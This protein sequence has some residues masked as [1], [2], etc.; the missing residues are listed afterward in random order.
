MKTTLLACV[1][2]AVS[3]GTAQ[4]QGVTI[5]RPPTDTT[6]WDGPY[7]GLQFSGVFGNAP[8]VIPAAGANFH[9]D[10]S[11]IGIGAFAGYNY[12][13]DRMVF[14]AEADGNWLT[15][16][17]DQATGVGTQ[18]YELDQDWDASLRLRAGYIVTDDLMFY[19]TGGLAVTQ[20]EANYV[21]SVGGTDSDLAW[22]W[23]AGAGA[24]YSFG[25]VTAR[26]QYRYSYYGNSTFNLGGTNS[27]VDYG[28]HSVTGAIAIPLSTVLG[29]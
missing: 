3:F 9:V 28:T 20:L 24:E 8:T 10:T 5:E 25:V 4:A 15:T 14:G 2:A 29:M 27:D 7:F 18:R 26:L 17:G 19:G 23:T 12:L 6:A 21:P 22:G 16:E 11:G 1:L 13:V